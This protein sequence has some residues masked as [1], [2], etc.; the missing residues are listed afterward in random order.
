MAH[1]QSHGTIHSEAREIIA[2][3][4]EKCDEEKLNKHFLLPVPAGTE[5]T[6][7]YA[8]VSYTTVQIIRKRTR[9]ESKTTQKAS[10]NHQGRREDTFLAALCV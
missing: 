8:G 10:C 4:I 3:I 9:K 2:N 6:A 5:H 7:V 1:R